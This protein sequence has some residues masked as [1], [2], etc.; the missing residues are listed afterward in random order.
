MPVSHERPQPSAENLAEHPSPGQPW[1]SSKL[2]TTLSP[3]ALGRR[4]YLALAECGAVVDLVAA[5]ALAHGL[6]ATVDTGLLQMDNKASETWKVLGTHRATQS[7]ETQHQM[8]L[9]LC[10]VTDTHTQPLRT[11]PSLPES[12]RTAQLEDQGPNSQGSAPAQQHGQHSSEHLTAHKSRPADM[13]WDLLSHLDCTAPAQM[14]G[15]TPCS[16]CLPRLHLC[17][18]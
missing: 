10:N 12:A 14:W 2:T 6:P 18:S 13:Q 7:E 8:Q 4:H 11:S 5:G 17:A 1:T 16:Q 9:G 15:D 3:H